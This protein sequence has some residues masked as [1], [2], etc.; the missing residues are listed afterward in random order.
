[1]N[2]DD[3]QPSHDT[4]KQLAQALGAEHERRLHSSSWL[5]LLIDNLFQLGLPLAL[6]LTTQ[7]RN[8]SNWWQWIA[9]A[10]FLACVLPLLHFLTYRFVIR[11]DDIFIRSG[12]LFR[13]KRYIPLAKIHN[14]ALKRNP[15][16][17]LLGVAEVRLE[18]G[19]T[20]MQSEALLRVLSL[21]DAQA[22]ERILSHQISLQNQQYENTDQDE[23]ISSH[24]DVLLTFERN[25]LL[26]Y[27]FISGNGLGIGGLLAIVFFQLFDGIDWLF[28]H[29]PEWKQAYDNG[30]HIFTFI[31]IAIA[32]I[33]V[34]ILGKLSAMVAAII[35]YGNFKFSLQNNHISQ[36]RGL[37]TQRHYHMP[38]E[39]IQAWRIKQSPLARC[40]NRYTVRI[41]VISLN[42]ADQ[43]QG[44][45]ELMP[46][47]TH[48]TIAHI[49]HRV[50]GI[51]I[52][53]NWQALHPKAWR[54][55]WVRYQIIIVP[56]LA[57]T[58]LFSVLSAA[59]LTLSFFNKIFAIAWLISLPAS[60]IIACNTAKRSMWAWDEQGFLHYR[61][62]I[63]WRTHHIAHVSKIQNLRLR[64][65]PFDR[66]VG[67]A[68]L[69]ADT[70]GASLFNAP[71]RL[72][73]LPQETA[74]MLVK[75]LWREYAV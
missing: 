8:W 54:K 61:T 21:A 66:K 15:L 7:F 3:F 29:F 22:M 52:H 59:E 62:G 49:L 73:Y 17:R 24:E 43:N 20:G 56:I 60:F 53:P 72:N 10:V 64:A 12:I 30:N 27:G 41:D 46:I 69:D 51:N 2:P 37:F 44:I 4:A 23:T 26:R 32:V 34:L 36:T 11:D 38:S 67:M 14:I 63:F 1:M 19:A 5:F 16:H 75:R 31:L 71:M 35:R 65:N 6:W 25:E 33:I 18:T 50:D 57:I 74:Q 28:S 9:A 39:K 40:F 68:H 70:R 47:A 42:A 45:A 55:L 48:E 58:W 13:Q